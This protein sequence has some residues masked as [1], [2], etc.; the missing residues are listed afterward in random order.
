MRCIQNLPAGYRENER[1]NLQTDRKAALT[2]NGAGLVLALA[3]LWSGTLMVP[4][5]GAFSGDG[6]GF[7]VLRFAVILLEIVAY[8]VLH[9]LT[10]AAVMKLCGAASVRFGFTGN[11]AYAGSEKDFF[12]KRAYRAVALAP[13]LVWGLLL[14]LALAVAP[15]GWF[16]MLW[17]IQIMNIAGSAGD[18]YVTLRF[19]SLPETAWIR[20]TGLEM[21]VYLPENS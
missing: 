16:W 11:Y 3:L 15:R 4:L 12:G 5:R 2:V 7:A 18:L 17:F 9:E 8:T 19:R 10:H 13:L 14:T 20:D 6:P 21:A 1:V